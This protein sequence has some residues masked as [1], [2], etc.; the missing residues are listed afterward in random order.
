MNLEFRKYIKAVGTGQKL[1]RDLTAEEAERAFR[2]LLEGEVTDA[3]IGGLLVPLRMKGESPDELAT[4]V[5]VTRDFCH[6]IHTTLKN[7]VDCGVAYDGK[8]KFPHVT[9]AAAFVAAGAGASVLLHGQSHTPPKYGV[10]VRDVFLELGIPIDWTMEQVKKILEGVGVGFL[11]I[12]QISPRVA[13]LKRIR[14]EL[15]LR[16]AFNHIE[17]LWNPINASHQVVSIYHGPYLKTIPDVLQKLNVSHALVIQGMEGTP[18]CRTNRVTKAV[19]VWTGGSK[20]IF[21]QPKELG[22][23]SLAEPVF[24]TLTPQNNAEFVEKS[25]EANEGILRDLAILNGAI[26]IYASGVA[27]DLTEAVQRARESMDSRRA[28]NKLEAL[29]KMAETKSSRV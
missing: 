17:K 18:D 3:Q 7:L 1:S 20:E 5:K 21:I 16:T 28:L 12:E 27:K 11:S 10:S 15:G 14:E 25:L 4:F 9:P 26:L 19:E 13:E 8:V 29:R 22:F 23:E 2:L 24:E 6:K